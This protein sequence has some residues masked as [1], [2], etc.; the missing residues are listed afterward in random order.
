MISTAHG[1]SY[2][3]QKEIID[4]A[5]VARVSRFIAPEF[6][7]DSLNEQVQERLPPNRAKARVIKYLQEQAAEK[8]ISWAAIATGVDLDR[9]LMNGKLGFDIKWQSATLHGQGHEHFA[10]SSSSWI[11]KVVLAV[12]RHWQ[13]VQNQYLY[14]AGT[15]TTANGIVASFEK[16]TGKKFEVSR[17]D[18]G[19]CVDEARKRIERGFPDAGMFLMARSVMY[20]ES[21]RAVESFERDDGKGRLGLEEESEEDIVRRIAHEIEHHAVGSCG[22]D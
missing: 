1:G 21:I 13:E 10:A 20:D 2:D 12:I 19:E 9:G 15:I 4:S 7:Q 18:V 6:G 22:C 11:G 17:G 3:T 14:A 5:I 8:R 16:V